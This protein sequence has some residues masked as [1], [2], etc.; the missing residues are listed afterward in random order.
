V[1]RAQA[2]LPALAIALL[3]VVASVAAAVGLAGSAF[4]GADTDP[5]EDRLAASTADRLV[6]AGGPLAV[7]ANVLSG[8]AGANAG[9][10]L[11]GVLP[12]GAAV[13]VCLFY[14]SPSPRD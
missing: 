6:A 14:T 1:T 9:E 2:N 10:G 4:A 7:R 3:L 13:R 5:A 11:D 12:A 8:A